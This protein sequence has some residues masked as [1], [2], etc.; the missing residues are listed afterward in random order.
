MTVIEPADLDYRGLA[1]LLGVSVETVKGW[2][3][4]RR[5]PVGYRVGGQVRFRASDVETWL[6]AQ[7]EA[8]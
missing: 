7:R 3:K 1:Q 4:R 5:G 6:Q 8:S 2:R